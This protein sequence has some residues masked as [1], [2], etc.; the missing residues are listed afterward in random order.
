MKNKKVLISG[1]GIAGFTLAYWLEKRGFS[2]TIVEKA[3]EMRRGGY[4]VDVRGTALDIVREMGLYEKLENATVNLK[5]SKI[6][7]SK[8]KSYDL[9][10][11]LL[12]YCSEDDIEVN[13]WDLAEILRQTCKDIEIIY[14]DS[15]TSIDKKVHFEKGHSREFDIIVGA[16]G[17]YSNVRKLH[18]KNEQAYLKKFG[19]NFCIF[20]TTNIF[21]LNECEIVY[22]EKGLFLAAYAVKNHSYTCLACKNQN[23]YEN[24]KHLGWKIPQVLEEMK[25]SDEIYYNELTQVRM[26]TWSKE[27]VALVGDAAHACSGMGTSLAIVGPYVLAKELEKSNGDYH[28]GFLAY[29]KEIRSFVEDAQKLAASNHDLLANNSSSLGMKLQLL[30]IKLLPRAFVKCLTRQGRKKMSKVSRAYSIKKN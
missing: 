4:K 2:P 17:I 21:E 11:D 27:N 5:T 15:I 29:E 12:G 14:G 28:K 3:S 30:L 10:G 25:N 8:F 23:F 6:V 20:P 1:A 16:D 9:K 13:R 24:F 26:P 18:F 22:F 19:V 7:T